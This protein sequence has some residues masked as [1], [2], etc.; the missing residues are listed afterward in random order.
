MDAS[1]V[2]KIRAL[3]TRDALMRLIEEAHQPRSHPDFPGEEIERHS[4]T[5]YIEGYTA[6]LVKVNSILTAAETTDLPAGWERAV[7]T[8]RVFDAG[9]IYLLDAVGNVHF[10]DE[11]V[12]P[13]RGERITLT[14]EIMPEST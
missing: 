6:A 4:P 1:T 8:G 7:I 13:R 14:L 12:R 5:A 9:S 2:D 11:L 10:L 3:S